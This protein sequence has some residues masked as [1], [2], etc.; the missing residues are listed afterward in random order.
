[1]SKKNKNSSKKS[2]STKSSQSVNVLLK[3]N[4]DKIQIFIL[5]IVFISIMF[6]AGSG[7]NAFIFFQTQGGTTVDNVF[8]AINV[9]YKVREYYS[10][11]VYGF[12]LGLMINGMVVI[13]IIYHDASKKNTKE[14]R[15]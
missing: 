8:K 4:K 12:I 2:S 9:C 14:G 13:G 7:Y 3:K 6:L 10:P 15:E 5:G 11:S 1:M